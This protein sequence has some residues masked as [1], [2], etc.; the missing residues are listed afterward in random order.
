M[1]VDLELKDL[2]TPEEMDKLL[3]ADFDALEVIHDVI[4]R[5]L[6]RAKEEVSEASHPDVFPAEK[7]LARK[8]ADVIQE[9]LSFIRQAFD[10]KAAKEVAS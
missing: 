1:S 8:R 9:Y 6:D 10:A 5:A 2:A 4:E 3:D 7:E